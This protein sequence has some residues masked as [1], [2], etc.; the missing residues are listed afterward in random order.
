VLYL[1]S[2]NSF[3]LPSR[4]AISSADNVLYQAS[5]SALDSVVVHFNQLVTIQ[6]ALVSSH[7]EPFAIPISIAVSG[8]ILAYSDA[9]NLAL[10]LFIA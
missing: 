10:L 6:K 1:A 5:I 4:A 9:D 7:I 8:V 3:A 2:N